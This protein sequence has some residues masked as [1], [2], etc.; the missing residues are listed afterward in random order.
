MNKANNNVGKVL[1]GRGDLSEKEQLDL[2]A[3][4]TLSEELKLQELMDMEYGEA[5]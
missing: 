4:E 5:L 3:S 2:L 1:E